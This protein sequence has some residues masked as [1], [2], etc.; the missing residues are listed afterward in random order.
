MMLNSRVR[1]ILGRS[2]GLAA[3]LLHAC[4][5][6]GGTTGAPTGGGDAPQPA[7][8]PAIAPQPPA[9]D[10]SLRGVDVW[11]DSIVW[12]TGTGGTVLRS[13]DAGGEWRR[14]AVPGG[15]ALDFRDVE[16]L[17]PS[18]VLLMS[19]GSGAASRIYRTT[20]G[21]TSWELVLQ[22]AE[23][24]AFFN[25]FAFW[26]AS[27]G[28]LTSD[29]YDGKPYFLKTED[30]G[31]SWRR[32]G[33]TGLPPLLEGE[34]NFAASGTC[35]AVADGGYAWMATGGAAARVFRSRDGGETWEVSE[36]PIAAGTPSSGIFSVAFRDAGH[37]V[38]VGGDYQRPEL[39][40]GNLAWTED[41]GKT[42]NAAASEGPITQKASVVHL[43][44]GRYLAA[45]RAGLAYSADDGRTWRALSPLG[46]YAA[47]Y[48]E[49]SGAG[50]LVGAGGAM[51]RF[52]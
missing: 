14:V 21:G 15:E 20:D 41:G 8:P 35:V 50:W 49:A 39:D 26:D 24:K 7:G 42:W 33:E 12:A 3:L 27:R 48:D 19:A 52:E 22:N 13:S 10:A 38:A 36:T 43:G 37:G 17:S 30:G 51:A 40:P 18:T 28:I 47:A 11:G 1:P 16:I 46:F 23:E 25:S 32:V 29:S 31:T 5:G 44:G 2:L 4:A 9:A 45:G 6:G 34:Y